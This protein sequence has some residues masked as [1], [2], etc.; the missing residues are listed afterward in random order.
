MSNAAAGRYRPRRRRRSYD[1][2]HNYRD[3][4]PLP[5]TTWD[6]PRYRDRLRNVSRLLRELH[7]AAGY[8]AATTLA[9]ALGVA[10]TTVSSVLSG[11]RLPSWTLIEA[12]GRELAIAAGADRVAVDDALRNMYVTRSTEESEKK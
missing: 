10:N 3:L 1:Y 4:G 5:G 8:P 2:Q 9:D 6:S 12:L 7:V 11:R